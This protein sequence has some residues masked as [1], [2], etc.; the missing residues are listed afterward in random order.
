MQPAL[1]EDAAA[2]VLWVEN[3]HASL[4]MDTRSMLYAF[5]PCLP[6]ELKQKLEA[7]IKISHTWGFVRCLDWGVV[8]NYAKLGSLDPGHR[9]GKIGAQV[10]THSP[11]ITILGSCGGLITTIKRVC[12]PP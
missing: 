4:G 1:G 8:V 5:F 9:E 2:F 6:G 11:S 7:S 3:T 12:S 10:Y